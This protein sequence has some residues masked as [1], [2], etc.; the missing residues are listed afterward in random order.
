MT[1]EPQYIDYG[2][3]ERVS[4][5]VFDLSVVLANQD[6]RPVVDHPRPDPNAPCK[7]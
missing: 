2:H 4:R 1:D 3:L 5:Y 6:A 7:Q